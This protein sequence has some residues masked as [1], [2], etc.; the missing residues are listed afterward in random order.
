MQILAF[1][2]AFLPFA[3]ADKRP[4]DLADVYGIAQV[5]SPAVAPDGRTVVFGVRRYDVKGGTSWSELWAIGA[6][7][8]GQRQLTFAKKLDSDPRFTPD[9]KS[10]V[11][12]SNRSGSSQLWSLPIDGGEPRQLTD[13]APGVESPVISPDGR[14]I[15]ATCEVWPDLDI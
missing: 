1:A 14:W 12:V 5:N 9:G 7:G 15:A 11:F 8:T 2:L 13:Y 6:D 3:P 4:F 10:V